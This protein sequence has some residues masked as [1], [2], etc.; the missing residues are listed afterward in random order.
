MPSR[1]GAIVVLEELEID[2]DV[3]LQIVNVVK[4]AVGIE[5][6][7]LELLRPLSSSDAVE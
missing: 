4:G 6:L 2:A 1:H 3:A 7:L 5:L